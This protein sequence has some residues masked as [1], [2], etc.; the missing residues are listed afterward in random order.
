MRTKS[1]LLAALI[2][3]LP[4][5]ADEAEG[6]GAAGN[7]AQTL[8]GEYRWDSYE[9]GRLEAVF[10]PDGAG[11]WEVAFHF[12]WSGQPRIFSGT[13]EGNLTSGELR[14]EVQSENK[15]R[16]WVFRGSFKNGKFR[17]THAEVSWRGRERE[18]GTLTLQR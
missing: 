4:A 5:Y 8:T 13:A 6:S 11:G 1:A 17:G 3:L 2:L 10:T 9:R 16:T 12:R 14:G 18:T 7:Q 15:R